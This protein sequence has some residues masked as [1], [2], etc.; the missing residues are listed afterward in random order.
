MKQIQ[1][2]KTQVRTQSTYALAKVIAA[3]RRI[4]KSSCGNIWMV[5]S[6]NGHGF[7]KIEYTSDGE[8]ICECKAFE[9][10]LDPCK[11]ICAIALKENK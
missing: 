6:S 8:F 4:H 5:E 7:Y 10:G 9:Y 1:E 2:L 3:S 11:H